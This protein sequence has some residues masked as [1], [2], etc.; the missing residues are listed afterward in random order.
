MMMPATPCSRI[1]RSTCAL[2]LEVLVG[3]GEDRHEAELIERLL[4]AH[5]ELGEEGVASGR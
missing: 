3:V 1:E 2:A 5:R 4:D